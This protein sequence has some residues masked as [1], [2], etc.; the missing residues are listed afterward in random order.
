MPGQKIIV[1]L[2]INNIGPH[3]GTN[4]ISFTDEV[5]SN[6]AIFYASNG[7]GK[8]FIS[9]TFRLT[10][11]EKLDL[12]ADDLLTLGQASGTLNLKIASTAA[13]L[14]EKKLSILV[15][16]GTP[17]VVQN[18]SGFIFH[19][20]NSDFVEENIKPRDYTPDG[21]IE[22]YILGKVQIDLTDEKKREEKLKGE[23]KYKDGTIDDT[24]EKAKKELRDIGVLPT[25]TE[26]ALIDK[27][28]LLQKET[29]SDVQPFDEIVKQLELMKK[30]PEKLPDISTPSFSI[31]DI[32][33]DEIVT[34]LTTVYPKA[35]WDEEFA[36]DIKKN[37]AF[38]EKGLELLNSDEGICPFCKQSLSDKALELIYKYK[39]FLA[40]KEAK[41][42]QKI[43][44]NITAIQN[45]IESIKQFIRDTKCANVEIENL[46]KYFPSL[47]KI[48]L[49]ISSNDEKVFDCFHRLISLLKE[50]SDNIT[51]T[52]FKV[53]DV[54]TEC[55][56]F[57]QNILE[58]QKR[59]D[60]II[61]EVNKTKQNSNGE[62]LTL[63]RNLCKA[64]YLKLKA[65]C[66][67]L[68][69]SWKN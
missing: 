29:F 16:K 9:R 27:E 64:Q 21:N 44:N 47:E 41:I 22:G 31:K 66:H 35:E 40:G 6:K 62:R 12:N 19:V 2:D 43:E 26:F 14:D 60:T 69:M 67:P 39:S 56:S 49:E 52:D 7:T 63:R 68:L 59:N 3:N 51:Y 32:V 36:S 38:V 57:I 20:F 25:T 15:N 61:K 58:Q 46:K 5:D 50:K 18:D 45:A 42:L 28:R 54:V 48:T 34:I 10:S 23:I 30:L 13:S 37:R 8:S 24:I 11:A 53:E 65:V 17:A 33:F 4:K 55:K 1:N